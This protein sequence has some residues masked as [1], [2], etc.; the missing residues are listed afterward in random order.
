MFRLQH[1]QACGRCDMNWADLIVS[2]CGTHHL[3]SNAPAYS[4]RFEEVLKFHSTGL[5]SVRFGGLA[6]HI[7][8][9]GTPAYV[10]RFNRTFGFYEG[11]AA[12]VAEEGA[13]HITHR[14]EAVYSDRYE[15][16]AISKA[17]IVL[18]GPLMA[19]TCTLPTM[20][21]QPT[22]SAGGMSAIFAMPLQLCSLMT[23]APLTS[24]R[25]V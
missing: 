19:P 20:V 5:A 15:W 23:V 4:E 6:W 1:A 11:L 21:G 17:A 9:D 24:T 13:F 8:P 7:Q 3:L 16:C 2:P 25:M 10:Q 18:L 22:P 14:G 12:V